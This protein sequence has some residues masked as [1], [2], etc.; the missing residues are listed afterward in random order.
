[1]DELVVSRYWMFGIIG[2]M[3][4]YGVIALVGYV[5]TNEK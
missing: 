2:L 4:V 5:K 3:C 1:M